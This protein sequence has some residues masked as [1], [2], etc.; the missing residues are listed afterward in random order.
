M[1]NSE[2]GASLFLF[3]IRLGKKM[4]GME[5]MDNSAELSRR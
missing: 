2:K 4:K 1:E 3:F 5:L